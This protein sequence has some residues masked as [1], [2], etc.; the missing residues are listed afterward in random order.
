MFDLDLRNEP[1]GTV[2]MTGVKFPGSD[3]VFTYALLKAGGFWYVTGSGKVP[4]NAGWGAVLNWLNRDEK[5]VEWIK[6]AEE[7]SDIPVSPRPTLTVHE[8][9]GKTTG[10]SMDLMPGWADEMF[11]ERRSDGYEP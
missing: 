9:I 2:L 10:E 8:G 3:R 6:R 7:W 4:T 5:T 11:L 1:E